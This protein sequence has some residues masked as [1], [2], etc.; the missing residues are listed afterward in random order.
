MSGHFEE[1]T[2]RTPLRNDELHLQDLREEGDTW[3][4]NS[5]LLFFTA[6]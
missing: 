4:H 2:E 1:V 5:F 3:H 6:F